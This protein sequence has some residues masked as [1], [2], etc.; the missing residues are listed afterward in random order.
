MRSHAEG[1]ARAVRRTRTFRYHRKPNS[2]LN[3]RLRLSLP[4]AD[5]VI[6]EPACGSRRR[7]WR[8]HEEGLPSLCLKAARQP[9]L[10]GSG[11][12]L[13]VGRTAVIATAAHVL[14]RVGGASVLTVGRSRSLLLS[15][16]RRGFGHR[17]GRSVDVDLALLVL[18]DDERDEMRKHYTFSYSLDY[19]P[20]PAMHDI[21]FYT[22]IGYLHSRNKL[23][24]PLVRSGRVT[25]NYFITRARLPLSQ[26]K[27]PDKF[28]EF[29]F[30]LGARPKGAVG[31][32]GE[33]VSFPSPFGLS[34]GGVWW[35]DLRSLSAAP[36]PR[37]VGIA[38]EH[39]PR[40]GAFVCTRIENVDTMI[41]DLL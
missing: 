24:P 3:T 6:C 7:V 39:H 29:H 9:F 15:G 31:T 14:A 41:H 40:A 23:S 8:T 2:K 18:N 22:V 16:E 27:S 11:I 13:Q 38:I 33:K 4:Y 5:I 21:A 19:A 34:G 20:L 1:E 10:I 17:R 35:L 26:V 25:A 37:L 36:I 30:A 12:P 28:A 32:V